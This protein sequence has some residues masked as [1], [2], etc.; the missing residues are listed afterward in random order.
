MYYA[1]SLCSAS[2]ETYL[3]QIG[4]FFLLT[5]FAE[6]TVGYD[7]YAIIAGF[8]YD[9]RRCCRFIAYFAVSEIIREVTPKSGMVPSTDDNDFAQKVAFIFKK[10]YFSTRIICG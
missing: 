3:R 5:C 1:I 6:R 10:R 8:K 9:L 4:K 2:E 7:K